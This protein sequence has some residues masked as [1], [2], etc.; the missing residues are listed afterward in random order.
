MRILAT[1]SGSLPV[2]SK[3]VCL[4]YRDLQLRC[5]LLFV[6]EGGGCSETGRGATRRRARQVTG[7]ARGSCGRR[8]RAARVRQVRI[9]AILTLS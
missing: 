4:S 9:I 5:N 6:T 3:A 1:R 2:G 7:G 8:A